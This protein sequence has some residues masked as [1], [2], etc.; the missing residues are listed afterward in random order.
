MGPVFQQVAI[1]L[2]PG[3]QGADLQAVTLWFDRTP[4]GTIVLDEVGFR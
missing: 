1:P 4:A 2:P 3:Y